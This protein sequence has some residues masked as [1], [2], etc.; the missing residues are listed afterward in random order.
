MCER[1]TSSDRQATQAAFDGICKIVESAKSCIQ[2]G[3]TEELGRLMVQNHFLLK[4]LQVSSPKLDALVETALAAGAWGAK[5]SGGGM[6]GNMIALVG[7]SS[8]NDVKRALINAGAVDVRHFVLRQ[9]QTS[10]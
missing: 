2:N 7:N 8:Q 3:H 10:S 1:F 5:M 6:G 4:R 9:E